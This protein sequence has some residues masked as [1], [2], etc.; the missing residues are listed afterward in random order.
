MTPVDTFLGPYEGLS[1]NVLN[2]KSTANQSL[3]ERRGY[4]KNAEYKPSA[5][6]HYRATNVSMEHPSAAT[7]RSRW[8]L[9]SSLALRGMA[10]VPNSHGVLSSEVELAP[11]TRELSIEDML[12]VA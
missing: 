10:V 3:R 5:R 4:G 8:E 11:A 12:T 2:I 6:C 7:I 1:I 9:F